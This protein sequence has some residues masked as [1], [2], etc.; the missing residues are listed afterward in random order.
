[1]ATVGHPQQGPFR[2]GQT[3]VGTLQAHLTQM[4]AVQLRA[5]QRGPFQIG[6]TEVEPPQVGLAK[7]GAPHAGT[8]DSHAPRAV[9]TG[10]RDRIELAGGESDPLQMGTTQIHT[11]QVRLDEGACGKIGLRPAHAH[12]LEPVENLPSQPC[13][14]P[15]GRTP[16]GFQQLR[17]RE[18]RPAHL[19]AG[20]ITV[21]ERGARKVGLVAH[22]LRPG[23]FSQVGSSKTGAN[24]HHATQPGMREHRPCAVGTGQVGALEV[25]TLQPGALEVDTPQI[26]PGEICPREIQAGKVPDTRLHRPRQLVAQNACLLR[27]HRESWWL[28]MGRLQVAGALHLLHTHQL[29][30]HGPQIHWLAAGGGLLLH[31]GQLRLGVVRRRPPVHQVG[32]PDL[33]LVFCCQRLFQQRDHVLHRLP[34]LRLLLPE[35]GLQVNRQRLA[36]RRRRGLG[37]WHADA[38]CVRVLAQ[39][40]GPLACQLDFDPGAHTLGLGLQAFAGKRFLGCLNIGVLGVDASRQQVAVDHRIHG[41]QQRIGTACHSVQV[42]RVRPR[43]RVP[44]NGTQQAGDVGAIV[45]RHFGQPLEDGY[46]ALRMGKEPDGRQA[47]WHFAHLRLFTIRHAVTRKNTGPHTRQLT[48]QVRLA[49][50]HMV[51]S[52][53]FI[54]L[55]GRIQPLV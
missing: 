34:L 55:E 13:A 9:R 42:V 45:R 38:Q 33:V 17:A 25:G 28:E 20:E 11:R 5:Y 52:E 53:S 36:R 2:A 39:L 15:V 7:I 4:R 29:R 32:Q 22:T 50:V 3:H 16:E 47:Q 46:T 24:R 23:G 26:K 31:R 19:R 18:H 30:K 44:F 14:G 43:F 35:L 49:R 48:L 51:E 40:D 1:M 37:L 6:C 12:H 54:A 10:H 27:R 8:L 21:R 41:T